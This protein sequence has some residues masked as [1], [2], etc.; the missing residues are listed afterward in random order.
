MLTR[1]PLPLDLNSFEV[2]DISHFVSYKI[3]IFF[4]PFFSFPTLVNFSMYYM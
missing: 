3:I 2:G 4:L 1:L